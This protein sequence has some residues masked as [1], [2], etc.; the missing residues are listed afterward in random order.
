MVELGASK[1][2]LVTHK[3]F[4]LKEYLLTHSSAAITNLHRIEG[5]SENYL[6]LMMICTWLWQSTLRFYKNGQPKLLAVYDA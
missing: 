2:K 5:L 6:Y 4:I 3:E 1:T